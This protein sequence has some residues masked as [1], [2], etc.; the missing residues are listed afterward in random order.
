MSKPHRFFTCLHLILGN[1]VPVLAF[2]PGEDAINDTALQ[3][4]RS[5]LLFPCKNHSLKYSGLTKQ[6]RHSLY[7]V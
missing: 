3:C 7:Q 2:S 4:R 1:N 5:L 6:Q